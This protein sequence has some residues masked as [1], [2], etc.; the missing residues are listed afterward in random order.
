[1]KTVVFPLL[2]GLGSFTP[3]AL[4]DR[5]D[6]LARTTCQTKGSGPF[7][8]ETGTT[9]H[10]DQNREVKRL[11]AKHTDIIKEK[12]KGYLD[13][14][15]AQN[16][17]KRITAFLPAGV[18]SSCRRSAVGCRE[19]LETETVEL[20]KFDLSAGIVNRGK[21]DISNLGL[22]NSDDDYNRAR[23]KAQ[24][25]ILKASDQTMNE[26]LANEILPRI[27]IPRIARVVQSLI[28]DTPVRAAMLTRLSEVRYGGDLCRPL[29]FG[30]PDVT[31]IAQIGA[32]YDPDSN[33]VKICRGFFGTNTSL[34]AL[35]NTVAHEI[36][37]SI[38]PCALMLASTDHPQYQTLSERDAR[39]PWAEVINC[40][41]DERST[42]ARNLDASLEPSKCFKDQ[43]G[44][45]IADFVA[46][47]VMGMLVE[48][49]LLGPSPSERTAETME[50][51]IA[52]IWRYTCRAEHLG[53]SDPHPSPRQRIERLTAV[54]PVIRSA[55][56]CGPL[57]KN[58]IYC[59]RG[60]ASPMPASIASEAEAKAK[61]PSPGAKKN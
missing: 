13:L 23:T 60:G 17:L 61:P 36:T 12:V 57:P 59:G 16:D 15:E 30:G 20:M 18:K 21:L 19:K 10:F 24:E 39:S 38:D 2:L 48:E 27:L 46:T 4:A 32:I 47:E 52:N 55:L 31:S 29:I 45:S 7:A 1:M 22:L 14:L 6:Q 56:G 34:Y 26:R 41:R 9:L 42:G 58:R 37:H 35:Y 33:K 40:L 25:T 8:D 54:H 51:G 44:E 49:G 3:T 43:I 50:K 53:A 5:C 11:I 28:P